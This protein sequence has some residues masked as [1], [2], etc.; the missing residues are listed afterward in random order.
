[1]M[2]IYGKELEGVGGGGYWLQGAFIVKYPIGT[3]KKGVINTPNLKVAW[4]VPVRNILYMH[5]VVLSS[6]ATQCR[7]GPVRFMQQM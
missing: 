7:V 5:L 2:I 1:M 6:L 3:H 4:S